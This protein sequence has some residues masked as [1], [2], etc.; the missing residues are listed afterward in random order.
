MIPTTCVNGR[1]KHQLNPP[2]SQVPTPYTMSSLLIFHCFCHTYHT[3]SCYNCGTWGENITL[4]FMCYQELQTGCCVCM[5]KCLGST[6]F[7][8]TMLMSI[9]LLFTSH[10]H[11]ST[12]CID[13]SSYGRNDIMTDVAGCQKFISLLCYHGMVDENL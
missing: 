5:V 7:K 12:E 2:N 4:I 10:S 11:C 9:K 3:S 13:S 8:A 6:Q 1:S